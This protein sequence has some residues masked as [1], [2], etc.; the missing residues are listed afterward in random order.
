MKLVCQGQ[1]VGHD[2]RRRSDDGVD[3]L[4]D[5]QQQF[6]YGIKTERTLFNT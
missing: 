2:P 3:L 5:T 4:I 6:T 1:S